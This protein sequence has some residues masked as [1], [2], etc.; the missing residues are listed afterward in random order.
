MVLASISNWPK[1]LET[2]FQV[3]QV[4]KPRFQTGQSHKT[5][6]L[7]W[8]KYL[9]FRFSSCTSS[10]TRIYTCTSKLLFYTKVWEKLVWAHPEEKYRG[11]LDGLDALK[12][13][14]NLN[15]E[16]AKVL[17]IR[18]SSCT[19]H[20]TPILNWPKSWNPGFEL[21]KVLKMTIFKWYKCK[22]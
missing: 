5:P 11:I 16:L 2:G 15:L 22:S 7:N 6:V 3:V 21:A 13:G 9:K 18:F 8:P 10:K 4:I 17:R 1:S 14:S 20:K 12:S 19:S